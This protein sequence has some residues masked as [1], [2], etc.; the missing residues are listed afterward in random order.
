M[1]GIERKV[2]MRE[3]GAEK[4]VL[5]KPEFATLAPDDQL[6]RTVQALEANNIR[7]FVAQTSRE[8]KLKILEMLHPGAEVFTATSKTLEHI[9]VA[10]E[11]NRSGHFVS[12]RSRIS[13]LDRKTQAHRIR[14]IAATAEYVVGSVHAVT[15]RGQVMIASA[16]GSQLALYSSGAGTLIWVVGTQK[17]VKDLDEGFRR[18]EEYAYPL[19]D[20][21]MQEAH[22]LRSAI[23]KILIV[24]RE[25]KPGRTTLIFVKERLG[26]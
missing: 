1:Y 9:G 10:E 14:L 6:D 11:I 5:P 15:E 20:A 19:E 7:T 18:I 13:K 25:G 23:N 17:I 21:R 12:L 26:F 16:S 22:R 2:R 24:N 4:V 8:A 3:S